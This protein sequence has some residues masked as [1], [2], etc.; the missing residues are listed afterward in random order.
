[1]S[2]SKPRPYHS[3]LRQQ[4]ADATRQR[5]LSAARTLMRAH[6][7]EDTG[8]AMIAK[9]AGVSAPAIYATF[10]SKR[11]IVSAL[12]DHARFGTAYKEH[13]LK[14]RKTEDPEERLR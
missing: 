4:Q 11:G 7:F 10:G 9:A 12:L 6:G 2:T 5:I 14:A 1:M 13:V 3:A 8:I